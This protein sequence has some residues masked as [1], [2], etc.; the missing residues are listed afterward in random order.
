MGIE[1]HG[2]AAPWIV[3]F[4]D[5]R[6]PSSRVAEQSPPVLIETEPLLRPHLFHRAGPPCNVPHDHC[7]R[8]TP[9]RP[10][11]YWR[12]VSSELARSSY[13]FSRCHGP[14]DSGSGHEIRQTAAVRITVLDPGLVADLAAFLRAASFVVTEAETTEITV[15]SPHG[16]NAAETR[17]DLSLRIA[18]WRAMNDGTTAEL[19]D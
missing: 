11:S 13:R 4:A 7:R 2:V 17:R 19:L 6:D 12:R 15:Q 16:D 5:E 10:R 18:A 8:S 14:I 9:N 1:Q 3:A